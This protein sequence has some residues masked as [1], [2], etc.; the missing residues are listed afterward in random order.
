MCTAVSGGPGPLQFLC[1]HQQMSQ[2]PTVHHF[3]QSPLQPLP[4]ALHPHCLLEHMLRQLRLVGPQ[5]LEELL[6]NP[7]HMFASPLFAIILTLAGLALVMA[8]GSWEG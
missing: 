6:R 1:P 3:Q 8:P 2:H 7:E 4:V 5:L